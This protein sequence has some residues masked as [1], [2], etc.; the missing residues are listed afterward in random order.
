MNRFR[1]ALDASELFELKLQNRRYTWSN[2]RSTPTLVHL[3][4]V[5]CNQDWAAMFPAITLQ[6]LS[7]SLSDHCPLFLCSQQQRPRIATFKFEQFWTRIPGFSEIVAEART[8]PVQ[9]INGMMK[10]HNRMQHTAASL[11]NWSK[12]LFSK[13]RAQLHIAN[14]VIL[15]L[16]IA[17]ES[18]MLSES[19]TQLLKDLKQH[20]L[21]WAAIQRSRRRQCSRLIQIKE[22]DACTKFFHQRANGRRKRN[23]IAY[24]KNEE[25][26]I[27][28]GHDEKEELL[29]SFYLNLLG[30]RS[31]CTQIFDWQRLNLYMV[32]DDTLDA[33][34]TEGEIEGIVKLIPAESTRA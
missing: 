7:S 10:L 22:G 34:F 19:E 15:R 18:R 20:V 30:T 6:A 13:A 24:L 25:D 28:W 32:E 9:G 12:A 14:E 33:P 27:V 26:N 17:Q 23:L 11:K 8:S 1:R 2:G 31:D 29:Y 3:D 21:G 5:F 16:D 4:R